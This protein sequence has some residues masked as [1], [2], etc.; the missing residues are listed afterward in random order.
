[1]E[2]AADVI[3]HAAE[4]HRPQGAQRHLTRDIVS[5]APGRAGVLAEEKQQLA[6]ARK[7]RR[8]AE[9]AMARIEGFAELRDRRGE[10]VGAGQAG[11]RGRVRGLLQLRGQRLGGLHH[12]RAIALPCARD[13]LQDVDESRAPPLRGGREVGA[14]VKR[15]EIGRQPHAHRPAAGSGRR[16]HERHVDAIDVGTLFAIDLDRDEVL[17][18]HRRH[19][20]VLE[21]LVR[22]HVAPVARRIADGEEDRLVF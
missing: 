6:R 2:P 4:R 16:L 22:H 10:G 9:A 20:V 7:L 14:A 19:R 12:L 15:L 3:A 11:R 17:V 5:T 1:M 21:R 8:V 18:E 13:L